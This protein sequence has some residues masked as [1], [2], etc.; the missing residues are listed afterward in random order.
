MNICI[1]ILYIMC[2]VRTIFPK[3]L[4]SNGVLNA[5]KRR[6]W[7]SLCHILVFHLSP[8]VSLL[9]SSV[10]GSYST[11]VIRLNTCLHLSPSCLALSPFFFS[12]CPSCVSVRNNAVQSWCL[13][14][15]LWLSFGSCCLP[16]NFLLVCVGKK[17]C[18]F[19]VIFNWRSFIPFLTLWILLVWLG[20]KMFCYDG[21][22]F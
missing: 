7:F 4:Q 17:A 9:L 8:F 6:S 21:S 11:I 19:V 15:T 5:W 2:M 14:W 13:R 22:F 16:W 3:Q 10:M 18:C 12:L 20:E 1:D